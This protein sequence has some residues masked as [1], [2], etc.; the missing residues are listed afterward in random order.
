MEN[1]AG[2]TNEGTEE[3]AQDTEEEGVKIRKQKFNLREF[4]LQFRLE[5]YC[6]LSSSSLSP[7][8]PD[9]QSE[10]IMTNQRV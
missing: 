8:S 7:Q 3:A 4:W 10:G 6:H 5:I 2:D 9:G 1:E